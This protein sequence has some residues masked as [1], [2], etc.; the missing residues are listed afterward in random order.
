MRKG[1]P[2]NPEGE[3]KTL[4]QAIGEFT[5]HLHIPLGTLLNCVPR[6]AWDKYKRLDRATLLR[7]VVVDLT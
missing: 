1:K 6:S 2:S 5:D 4:L 3:V 7:K